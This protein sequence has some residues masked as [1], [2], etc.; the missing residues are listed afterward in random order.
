M[1]RT[2]LITASLLMLLCGVLTACGDDEK[3]N[4]Q[5]RPG[6]PGDEVSQAKAFITSES[7]K[8]DLMRS[9]GGGDGA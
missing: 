7:F 8:G 3:M 1:Y 2:S 5:D 9:G 6:S 4:T